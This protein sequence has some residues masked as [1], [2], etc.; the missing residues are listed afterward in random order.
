MAAA[1]T[2]GASIGVLNLVVL[3]VADHRSS[4]GGAG[5]LLA[6]NAAG[7]LAGSLVYATWRWQTA[8]PVRARGGLVGCAAVYA[9][10]AVSGDAAPTVLW[11]AGVACT[12]AAFAVALSAILAWCAVQA[13][14]GTVTESFAWIVTVFT[15]GTALGSAAAGLAL[16]V[17]VGAATGIAAGVLALGAAATLGSRRV[18]EPALPGPDRPTTC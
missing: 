4:P 5:L 8:L 9:L 14:T 1:A 10:L 18:P 13:P 17:G 7:A 11:I 12:G 2:L 15:I 3:V 16:P 6:T